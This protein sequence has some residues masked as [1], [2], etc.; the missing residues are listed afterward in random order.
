MTYL[1]YKDKIAS[2]LSALVLLLN[3]NILYI[4]SAPMSEM[5]FIMTILGTMYYFISWI[6]T[7]KFLFLFFWFFCFSFNINSL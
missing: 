3:I 5:F 2:S 4:Q 7:D 1:S 6:F